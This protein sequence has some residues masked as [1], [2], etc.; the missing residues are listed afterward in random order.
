MNLFLEYNRI[1]YFI[2]T[3]LDALDRALN[4]K[5]DNDQCREMVIVIFYHFDCDFTFQIFLVSEEEYIL[6]D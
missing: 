4:V 5:N 1:K 3:W 6:N 2:Y